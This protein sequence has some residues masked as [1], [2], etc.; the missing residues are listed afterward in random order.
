M[1]IKITVV[2]LCHLQGFVLKNNGDEQNRFEQ[3][4]AITE[5]G[6]LGE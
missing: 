2:L 3:D 5:S 4:E 6:V 1:N